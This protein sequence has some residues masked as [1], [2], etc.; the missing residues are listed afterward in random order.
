MIYNLTYY[1]IYDILVFE[2]HESN[3]H[4]TF[5]RIDQDL[6]QILFSITVFIDK[7]YCSSTSLIFLVSSSAM[8]YYI[9]CKISLYGRQ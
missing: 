7:D 6:I 8:A 3:L 2:S 1:L 9:T 5:T 4:Y